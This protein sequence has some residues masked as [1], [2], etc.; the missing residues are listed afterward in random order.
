VKKKFVLKCGKKNE[1]KKL[2]M[3]SYNKKNSEKDLYILKI[4]QDE[5][6]MAVKKNLEKEV[7]E[8]DREEEAEVDPDELFETIEEE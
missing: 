2:I 1:F 7:E 8:F 6:N 5:F 4:R 3:A